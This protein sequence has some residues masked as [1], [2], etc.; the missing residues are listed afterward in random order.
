MAFKYVFICYCKKCFR[1]ES[2]QNRFTTE[3]HLKA[4]FNKTEIDSNVLF[5]YNPGNIRKKRPD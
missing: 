3:S 1:F 5:P 2:Q 4:N